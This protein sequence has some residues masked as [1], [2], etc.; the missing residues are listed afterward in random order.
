MQ[1]DKERYLKQK[2]RKA[3]PVKSVKLS[4]NAKRAYEELIQKRDERDQSYARHL[5]QDNKPR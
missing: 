4:D 3:A 2:A 5:S 1:D